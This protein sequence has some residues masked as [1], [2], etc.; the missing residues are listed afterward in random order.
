MNHHPVFS[1]ITAT[2]NRKHT[3][4]GVYDGLLRQTFADFEWIIVDDGSNDGTSELVAEWGTSLPIVYKYKENGGRPSAVNLGLACARGMYIVGLDSDDVP[5]P[6]AMAIFV[7]ELKKTPDDVCAVGV[8]T[9][10]MSGEI[11]GSELS[12]PVIEVTMLEAYSRH[13][14][15]GD[16]WLAFKAEAA[17]KFLFPTYDSEKFSPEGLVF[18]RMSRYGYKVRFINRPLLIHEYLPDGLTHNHLRLKANN[19]I[20]FIAYHAENISEHDATITLYYLKSAANIYVTL[21]LCSKR[22]LIAAMLMVLALPIGL[23]KGLVDKLKLKQFL[24][25]SNL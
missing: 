22:P 5:V 11:I 10:T 25:N 6:E 14:M 21:L 7:E 1:I 13:G 8:L 12:R 3:L 24:K 2:Y 19:P 20:G 16:K 18:N 15:T 17:K 9:M 23:I 4:K